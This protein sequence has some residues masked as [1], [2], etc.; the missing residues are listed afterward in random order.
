M[1]NYK[2]NLQSNNSALSANNIDLQSLI[3][4]ANNLPDA[5]SGVKLPTLVNEGAAIDLLEGKQLIDSEG[6]VVE[7]TIPH[8]T[9]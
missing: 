4:Q 9:A 6:N 2:F 3:E 1:S 8:K 7:G 5:S